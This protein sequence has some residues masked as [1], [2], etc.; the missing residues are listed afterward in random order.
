MLLM[1]IL[2]SAAVTPLH[3]T[4][5]KHLEHN[6][7]VLTLNIL[8]LGEIERMRSRINLCITSAVIT[9][10]SNKLFDFFIFYQTLFMASEIL[11]LGMVAMACKEHAS[12]KASYTK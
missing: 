3:G 8:L 5:T 9:N 1:C 4:V 7:C 12:M 6:I 11:Y 2:L 10:L